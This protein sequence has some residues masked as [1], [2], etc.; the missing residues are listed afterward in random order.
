[1]R[2]TGRFLIYK[3]ENKN[4]FFRKNALMA[5]QFFSLN[6]MQEREVKRLFLRS[7]MRIIAAR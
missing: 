3:T 5:P 1:L 4:F 2:Q 6:N 7:L